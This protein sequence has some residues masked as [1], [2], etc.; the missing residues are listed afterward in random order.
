MLPSID[1]L[2][3]LNIGAEKGIFQNLK[4]KTSD[5][6]DNQIDTFGLQC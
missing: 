1:R 5:N 3:E 4:N 6:S 2:Y